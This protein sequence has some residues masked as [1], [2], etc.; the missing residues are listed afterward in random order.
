MNTRRISRLNGF[1]ARVFF[2]SFVIAVALFIGT[3]LAIR[4]ANFI[5][6]IVAGVLASYITRAIFRIGPTDALFANDD[7]I[8]QRREKQ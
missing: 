4:E 3:S 8:K 2:L 5:I 7:E 1:R 6:L